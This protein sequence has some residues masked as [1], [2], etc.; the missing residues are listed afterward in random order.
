MATECESVGFSNVSLTHC[1]VLLPPRPW[2]SQRQGS[3][4]IDHN[5]PSVNQVPAMSLAQ[6]SF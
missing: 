4:F 6:M 5:A 1:T 3:M 2:A